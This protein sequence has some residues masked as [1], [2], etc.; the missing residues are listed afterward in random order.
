MRG[1]RLDAL[2]DSQKLLCFGGSPVG[3][4]RTLAFTHCRRRDMAHSHAVR[5][6][7]MHCRVTASTAHVYLK[8][9]CVSYDSCAVCP[10]AACCTRV[11]RVYVVCQQCPL[12]LDANV[13]LTSAVASRTS[14]TTNGANETA[15]SAFALSVP[16]SSSPCAPI[17]NARPSASTLTCC[18]QRIAYTATTLTRV[19]ALTLLCGH[20]VHS[21]PPAVGAHA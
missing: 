8:C 2:E 19:E 4:R 16:S 15:L 17:A 18:R 12:Y 13:A 6:C 10:R 11:V 1:R 20:A 7:C 9:R 21:R 14:T 3:H 5:P